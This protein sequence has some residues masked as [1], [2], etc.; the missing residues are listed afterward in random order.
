[1]AVGLTLLATGSPAPL[2][3]RGGS[4]YL[5]TIDDDVL[6]VDC[7]P[8]CVRRLLQH[9]VSLTRISTL[10]LTHLHYDHCVDYPYLVLTRWDQGVGSIDD[11]NVYG[12][13][14]T[15][16]MTDRFFADDGAF[17]HDLAARTEHEGSQFIY[18]KRGG[19][20]PRRRPAPI[21]NEVA[22][23]ST[24]DGPGWH[25]EVAEVLHC[26]PY[27]ICLG[28]RLEA[29]GKSIVFGGDSAPIESLTRLARGADVLLHMC[30][31][32]NGLETDPRITSCCSGHRD[33]AQTAKA[34]GVDTLVLVHITEQVEQPGVRERVLHEVGEIFDGRVIFGQDLLDVPIADMQTIN[35]R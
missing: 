24:L 19:V 11:L 2:N 33:A 22:S 18:E 14:G 13:A 27:L 17:C 32:V 10:L 6:L 12:P 9:G 26:Q 21:V 35:L 23:G 25:L 5:V 1:M 31:F 20:L 15:R 16:A 28:Y 4:S 34:A 8:A 29:Q 7:G 3:H 30:H